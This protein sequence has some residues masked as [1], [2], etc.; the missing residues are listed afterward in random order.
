MPQSS[1][2]AS[3]RG[4]P[5]KAIPIWARPTLPSPWSSSRDYLCPFCARH[6]TETV[7]A[8]IERYIRP[9]QVKWVFRDY[10]I[11]GLHPTAAQGHLAAQCVAEQGAALF[12]QMHDRLF[13]AQS[14]WS[15]LPD[16]SDYLAQVADSLGA[17]L[18][19]YN[20]CLAAGRAQAAVDRGIADARALGLQ[21]H[22]EFPVREH[23]QVTP[24]RWWARSPWK[25]LPSG[26]TRCWPARRRLQPTPAPKAGAALL[27]QPRGA[28]A[29]PR[30]TRLYHGRR[31]LQGQPRGS[32]GSGR[33]Q[34][35]PVPVV[36]HPCAGDAADA[37]TSSL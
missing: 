19:A 12:W 8:L 6:V 1:W 36:P 30:P 10:P 20:A 13:A 11:A 24:T 33:V 31:S 2:T 5:R 15:A 26:S 37:W 9:G 16:P 3:R 4:S 22:P 23:G 29:R 21:R 35:F 25:P 7:P 32:H 27:G 17:D 14:E 18:A 28:G 34:R